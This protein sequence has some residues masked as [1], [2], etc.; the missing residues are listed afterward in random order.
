MSGAFIAP[1]CDHRAE[2]QFKN[3]LGGVMGTDDTP[4]VTKR[5]ISYG[6]MKTPSRHLQIDYDGI[7]VIRTL[8]NL[9]DNN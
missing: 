8:S 1:N 7:R 6:I 2:I 5:L 4:R 3:V 9:K